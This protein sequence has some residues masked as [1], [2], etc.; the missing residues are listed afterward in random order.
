MNVVSKVEPIVKRIG[1]DL[2]ARYIT[3]AG[4]N[5]AGRPYIDAADFI[6][7]RPDGTQ[8]RVCVEYTDCIDLDEDCT[9]EDLVRAKVEAAINRPTH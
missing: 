5:T 2:G 7:E 1:P 6:F 3:A 8:A 4:A 9:L